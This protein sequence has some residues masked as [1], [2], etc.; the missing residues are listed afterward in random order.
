VEV[1]TVEGNNSDDPG[2]SRAAGEHMF[3][4]L[5]L[6]AA[7]IDDSSVG[8]RRPPLLV[9]PPA[10][11]RVTFTAG[12]LHPKTGLSLLPIA[13][14]LLPNTAF[15]DVQQSPWEMV[16]AADGVFWRPPRAARTPPVAASGSL[17]PAI[18]TP[19]SPLG[20]LAME[21][22]GRKEWV[23]TMLSLPATMTAGVPSRMGTRLPPAAAAAG[24]VS[25]SQPWSRRCQGRQHPPAA[26]FQAAQCNGTHCLHK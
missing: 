1:S 13:P 16:A 22:R 2:H 3:V 15:G 18:T 7:H 8:A 21:L 12:T 4:G 19:R 20:G 6:C 10:S 9:A 24:S 25:R 17:P 11:V 26:A 14:S 23:A 5:I